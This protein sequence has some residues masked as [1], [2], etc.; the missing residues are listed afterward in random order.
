MND[1]RDSEL[2]KIGVLKRREIEARI[3]APLL[4]AL[5]GEFGREKV[6]QIV[7]ETI[8]G[9]AIDLLY[10]IPST[11]WLAPGAVF[12]EHN[13]EGLKSE[14]EWGLNISQR[15]MTALEPYLFESTVELLINCPTGRISAAA[16]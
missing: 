12:V 3:L 1:A 11:V 6:L 10:L 2:N 15:K 8:V 14:R 16:K 9:I 5:S 4:D 13:Y 7:R